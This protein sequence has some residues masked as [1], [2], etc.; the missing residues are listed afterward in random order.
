MSEEEERGDEG[1]PGDGKGVGE[2]TEG[3]RM[4]R[5]LALVAQAWERGM[6]EKVKQGSERDGSGNGEK[7]SE[8][9]QRDDNG[10]AGEG[11]QEESR[12][13]GSG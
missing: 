1:L 2:M 9:R 11:R 5:G 13:G 12:E 3:E 10:E 6:R 4:E 8:G 7:Q